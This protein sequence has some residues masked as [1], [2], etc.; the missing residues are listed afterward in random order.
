MALSPLSYQFSTTDT[1]DKVGPLETDVS[2]IPFIRESDVDFVGYNLRPNREVW[3][4]FDDKNMDQFISRPNIIILDT[5]K[6]FGDMLF[7]APRE[8]VRIAGGRAKVLLN[9]THPTN[10]NTRLYISDVR[11]P[12]SNVGVGNSV[13]GVLTNLRGNVVSYQHFSGLVANANTTSITLSRDASP[14]NNYYSGNVIT[15]VTGPAAGQSA[16]IISYNGTTRA[17]TLSPALTVSP[18]RNDNYSIG[19]IRRNYASSIRPRHYTTDRGFIS[20]TLHLPDP[21][22]NTTYAFRTGDRIFRILDNPLNQ[23]VTT[24][25]DKAYTCR[26]DYRYTTNGLLVEQTQIIN[27]VTTTNVVTVSATVFDPIAQS[28]FVDGNTYKEGFFIPSIDLYFRNRGENL[29]VQVQ[30]RP[31]VEGYP[32]SETVLPYAEATLL[33][34]QVKVSTLPNTDNVMTAT[35]FTFPS[36]V[37]VS[38][39]QEYAF[40]ILTNDYGYDLW[41]SEV[42]QTQV[43][44]NRWVSEQP[45]LG[46]MFKSQSGR[47]F[48]ALQNEDVM[49]KI[50]KCVFTNSGQIVFSDRKDANSRLPYGANSSY[51]SNANFDFFNYQ[52][53]FVE[54]PGT[55]VNFLYRATSNTSKTMDVTYSEFVPEKNTL[56][57]ERKELFGP[58]YA[59]SFNVQTQLSTTNPDVSPVIF[60]NRQNLVVVKDIIN[61]M[62]ISNTLITVANAGTGYYNTNTSLTFSSSDTGVTANG[63]VVS[64]ANG[65]IIRVVIDAPGSGYFSGVTTTL[66][67]NSGVGG[68]VL[69][70]SETD[71]SGGPGIAKYVG[72]T[73]TLQDGFDAGDLRVYV[74]A[75]R[76]QSSNVQVYFK[77]KNS[78]DPD[79]IDD[80]NWVKMIQ[81]G[82][83]LKFSTNSETIEY[84]FRPSLTSNAVTYTTSNATYKTFNQ[85]KVKIVLASSSTLFQDVP[86]LYDI[87][88]IA[89]PADIF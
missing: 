64:D 85:F 3:Y 66:T 11:N 25:G 83:E 13:I 7:N 16:N 32:D 80:K 41:V 10:G 4:Y 55:K 29:P 48:T 20:G 37:Y 42:G 75:V 21:N 26:A 6:N 47:T 81:K 34:E 53:D 69:V 30:I 33:P 39:D 65:S 18:N 68:S 88:A 40:V 28:F 84:E 72:K 8:D 49:F 9:E 35:R 44:T 31:M 51:A 54:I 57:D 67:A 52:S 79:S 58:E 77:V 27:R 5:Q 19:D 24:D 38:P 46:S 63:F 78:L 89:L 73:V 62:E 70:S 61:N 22:A 50:N 2:V 36:P 56:L 82:N 59:P 15:V 1:V 71:P 45:Y 60:Y 14:T 43:G 76:P 86:L 23:L 12:T 74:T 17:A 87:R